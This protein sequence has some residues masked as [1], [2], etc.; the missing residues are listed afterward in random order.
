VA[1]GARAYLLLP[2]SCRLVEGHAQLAPLAHGVSARS[3]DEDAYEE[4]RNFKKCLLRMHVAAGAACVLFMETHLG[5][6][7]G[8]GAGGGAHCVI[9]AVP[10]PAAAAA[11]A[12]RFFR[13]AIDEAES[14]WST[15]DAK[16]C[17][18]LGGAGGRAL[19]N[20]VPPGFPYFHVEF[21]LATGFVHVIDD[22]AAWN[23]NFGRD[24]LIGLLGLPAELTRQRARRPAPAELEAQR[25]AFVKAYAP[26]DWTAALD[27]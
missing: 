2:E 9:D 7:G 4:L 17:I 11:A 10:L 22:T 1:Y 3:C 15:H 21:G 27:G 16:K 18:A 23:P 26:Y 25:A 14:E 12:P 5:G 6:G 20:A 24:V 13:T 8:G 19:R